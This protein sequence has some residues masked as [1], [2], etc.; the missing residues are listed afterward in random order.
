MDVKHTREVTPSDIDVV[1]DDYYPE[2]FLDIIAAQ[3]F[4]DDLDVLLGFNAK[5]P[6]YY[7]ELILRTNFLPH[8][9]SL[10]ERF[11][12]LYHKTEI[13]PK[14]KLETCPNHVTWHLVYGRFNKFCGKSCGKLEYWVRKRKEDEE[15]LKNK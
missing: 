5:H 10:K 7:I 15:K 14:C 13:T 9:A 8:Y 12:H 3:I 6:E 1:D 11:W 2:S 4:E